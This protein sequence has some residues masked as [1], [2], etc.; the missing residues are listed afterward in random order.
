M[1]FKSFFIIIARFIRR[2]P[3]SLLVLTV[4]LYLSFFKPP[5]QKIIDISNIDKFAHFCMY[6]GFCSIVWLEYFRSHKVVN[7][8]KTILLAVVAPI[9]FGGAIEIMQG[10]MTSYRGMDWHDFIFNTIGVLFALLFAKYFL[11]PW[12]RRYREKRN[13]NG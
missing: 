1:K 2:Y 3:L 8:G 4:I 13:G 11:H 7:R 9:M 6:A 10:T 5:K 12:V